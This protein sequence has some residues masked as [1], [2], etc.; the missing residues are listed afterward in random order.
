MRVTLPLINFS[1]FLFFAKDKVFKRNMEEN[2]QKKRLQNALSFKSCWKINDLFSLAYPVSNK[3]SARYHKFRDRSLSL[4][5]A[6]PARGANDD[7]ESKAQ[8]QSNNCNKPQKQAKNLNTTDWRDVDY[9]SF[10]VT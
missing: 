5:P 9:A 6:T 7:S 2:D 10:P 1:P 4:Q 8:R 3:K